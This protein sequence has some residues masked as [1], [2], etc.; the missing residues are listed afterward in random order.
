M[1]VYQNST[2][3]SWFI[4]LFDT[5]ELW[6]WRRLL[7]VPWTAR[8]WLI[9]KDSDAWKDWR[10]EEKGTTEDE[11]V[12][13]HHRLDGYQFEQ[14]SGVGEGQ[15]SLACYSPW[16]RKELDM[17]ERL[18]WT[19][20]RKNHISDLLYVKNLF[21]I[22]EWI[23]HLWMTLKRHILVIWKNCFSELFISYFHVSSFMK[24]SWIS[25]Y[26]SSK[27][28]LLISLPTSVE[29]SLILENCQVHSDRW[30]LILSLAAINIVST[31]PWNY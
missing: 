6:C 10:Q 29:K 16:G 24:C 28:H 4:G 25:L 27:W 26:N 9:G 30:A 12:G 20:C 23:L 3:G 31:L 11:M 8:R 22:E 2:C 21:C 15:G 17:T 14:A 13:W 19:W 18:N 7:R 1:I 5:F